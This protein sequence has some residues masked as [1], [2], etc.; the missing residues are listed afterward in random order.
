[1][2]LLRLLSQVS[3][4]TLLAAILASILSG[5]A[6]M[7]A[8][9]CVFESLRSGTVLW[10]QFAL[11]AAFAILIRE[12]SRVTLG[13]LATRSVLRLRRRL[14]R[15]VLH[16]PLLDLERIGATRLL[17]AFT[18]DLTGVALAVR[19]LASLFSSSAFLVALVGYLGWLSPQR[20]TV[21]TILL[22]VCIVGAVLMRRF[23]TEQR[24]TAREAWDRIVYVY[25]MLLDGVKQL[26][27]NRQLARH[28]LRSFEDRVHDQ[29]QSGARRGRSLD[30]VGAWVQFMFYV[31]LG[32]A[33]FGSFSDGILRRGYGY[34]LLALLHI[35]GPL[36]SLIADSRAFNDAS[37]ALQRI[38]EL[39]VT[40]SGDQEDDTTRHVPAV[41]GPWRSLDL[42]GVVFKYQTENSPDEFI[43]GP[44]DLTLRPGEIVFVAGGNGSGKTTFAKVLTAL[45]PPTAGSI[46]LDD[47]VIEE[48]SVR[49][50]RSKFS[51]VFADFCL[52][53]GVADLRPQQ[54][55]IEAER[56]AVRLKLEQW[57]LATP[58][59][60]GT[61]ATLSSGERRRVALLMALL[62]DRPILVFDEWAA[63]QD[64][65]Y[66]DLFYKEILPRIRDSGKLVVV[67]SHDE[68]YFP[69]ADRVLWLERGKPP[70]WRSPSS[71]AEPL[72]AVT[73]MANGGTEDAAAVKT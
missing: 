25:Q 17:V 26:K 22:L 28:V 4:L 37:V 12:Y 41:P 21:T 35:R 71:F 6:A 60:S 9:I 30:A 45:Y 24:H 58:D 64:P 53:E 3:V 38:T 57:M 36:R 65:R 16:V 13:R 2:Q 55:A 7:G 47:T 52:F 11:V 14:V 32:T 33:V 5:F 23:E 69:T 51:V 70:V 68:R 8:L 1:M 43:L 63:D 61:S 59:S 42:R 15:S 49:W 62:E 19:N 66:K 50:F 27:I 20:A 54:V 18:S 44:L 29:M 73:A 46:R 40:L 31:I 10:W 72:N 39:G 67:I 34:G 48:H 56:L